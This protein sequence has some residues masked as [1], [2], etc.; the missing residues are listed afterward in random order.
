MRT[1]IRGTK[2]IEEYKQTHQRMVDLADLAYQRHKADCKNW[3]EGEPVK[4]WFKKGCDVCIEYSSGA[5]WYYK[6]LELP[7]P[8]WWQI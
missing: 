3:E 1:V 2:T 7:F 5:V 4:A 6:D 8:S